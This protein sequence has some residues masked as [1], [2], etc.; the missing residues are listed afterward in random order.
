MSWVN[1][2]RNGAAVFYFK[3]KSEFWLGKVLVRAL[4]MLVRALVSC[5]CCV[6]T[7]IRM[8]AILCACSSAN[9]LMLLPTQQSARSSA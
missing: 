9:D 1:K 6:K 5:C 3:M 4:D 2:R 8:P 7:E